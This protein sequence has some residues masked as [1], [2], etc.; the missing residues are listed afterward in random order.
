[1]IRK[2]ENRDLDRVMEIWLNSNI[3]A[4]DFIEK[5]YWI[6]NYDMVKD[7]LPKAEVYVFEEKNNIKAFIGMDSGYIAGIFVDNKFRSKGIG[8]KLLQKC[9]ANYDKLTLSVYKKNKKAVDF[10]LREG[11]LIESNQPDPNTNEIEY[12]MIYNKQ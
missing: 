4:H 12:K 6:S 3:E 11:F 5:E 10:Y 2:L 7:I 9:K 1:M 8:K